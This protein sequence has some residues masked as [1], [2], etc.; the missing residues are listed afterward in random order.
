M[1]LRP[2]LEEFTAL[3]VDDRAIVVDG[4]SKRYAMTGFRVGWTVVPQPLVRAVNKLSQNLFI[5]V[6]SVSQHAAV[7]AIRHGG[8]V[9]LDPQDGEP[10]AIIIATGS[11]VGLA[12]AAARALGEDGR[13]VR[14]VSVPCTEAFAA[15]PAE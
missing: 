10:E 11:E 4:F 14:V 3:A 13:R 5:S 15:A 12:V 1:E 9:L 2:T 6:G 7:A 8:Y